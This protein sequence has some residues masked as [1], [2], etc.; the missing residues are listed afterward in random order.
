MMLALRRTAAEDATW[1]QRLFAWATR[2]RLVSDYCHGGIVIN[3]M[4]Y[5]VNAARGLHVSTYDPAKWDVY[6]V[7]GSDE[8]ALLLF[9]L[10]QHARYDYIGLLAFVTPW[11]LGQSG[12]L[13]CFEW[14]AL[15]LG[16]PITDRITPERLLAAAL[17]PARERAGF[18]TPTRKD[19]P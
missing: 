9:D 10:W 19:A 11:R 16:I 3:G 13:Y 12:R 5:Q 8:T 1:W 4:M 2:V 14:C 18:F 6:D 7:L 17:N 15:C